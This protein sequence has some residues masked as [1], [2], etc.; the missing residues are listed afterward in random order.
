MV[1]YG[2]GINGDADKK[3]KSIMSKGKGAPGVPKKRRN[4]IRGEDGDPVLDDKGK[5]IVLSRK[6]K[7][8]VGPP[9]DR[10][11]KVHFSGGANGFA[12]KHG[13]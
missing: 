12:I 10:E 8:W 1:L 13:F 9:P 6:P 3:E 7:D 4:P 5:P 2:I 11:H